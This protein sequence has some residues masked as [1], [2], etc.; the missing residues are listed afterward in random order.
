MSSTTVALIG[1]ALLVILMVLK[2][3]IAFA[4]LIIGCL[5]IGY[6]VSPAAV[7]SMV[8]TDIWANF[9]SYSMIVVP[10]FTFMGSVAFQTGIGE[11]LYNSAYKFIGHRR[12]GLALATIVTC[13]LFGAMCGSTSAEVAT[14]TKVALPEMD[15]Y[16]YKRS[17]STACIAAAGGLAILI[18]PSGTFIIYGCIT[19]DSIIK[20][21][22][23]GI[24]PGIILTLLFCIVIF[25]IGR[26]DPG[27][28]PRGEKHTWKERILSL[29]GLIEFIIL[30]FI[31]LVGL[32]VG[33]FTPSEAG[34]AGAGGAIVIALIRR[35]LT[36]KKLMAALAETTN[37]TGMI[38]LIVTC[39]QVFG[40]FMSLT[41]IPATLS[42]WIS[43]LEVAPAII[44]GAILI[45]YLI[46][47]CFMDALPL[48]TLTVP[49]L[50][51]VVT[52][53][54]GYSGIW[55]GVA[56]VLI[57]QMGLITPPVGMNVFIVK[58]VQ[59]DIPLEEIFRG[60]VPFLIAII[61]LAILILIFPQL[62]LW[63]PGVLA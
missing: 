61:V 21:F 30:V 50:Y 33:W 15:K 11:R 25:I 49:I 5:G 13:A 55:F 3:P 1:I 56:I 10:L 36:W 62:A 52:E 37:I 51:P 39:A 32:M 23:A 47:G 14:M 8:T 20:L 12:G 42:T 22:A 54:L 57:T 45:F 48:F 60:I 18:P 17:M 46:G 6:I 4:M 34:A 19:G 24:I 7:Y 53:Q 38:F 31:V 59:P 26:I 58:S 29:N 35:K 40:H 9:S 44:M 2:M 27:V 43:G 63:L 28:A 41:R 16:K